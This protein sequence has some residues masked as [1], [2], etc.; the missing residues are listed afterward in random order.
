MLQQKNNPG[1]I[2][3]RLLGGLVIACWLVACAAPQQPTSSPAM[4]TAFNPDVTLLVPTIALDSAATPPPPTTAENSPT[5]EPSPAADCTI[6]ET[7]GFGDDGLGIASWTVYCDEYYGFG[8]KYP[9]GGPPTPPTESRV[10]LYLPIAPDTTLVEKY[11]LVESTEGDPDCSSTL[12]QGRLPDSPQAE[13]ISLSGLTFTRQAGGDAAAGSIYDWVTY[14]TAQAN[15][16]VSLSFVLHH[17]N[18]ANYVPPLPEFDRAAESVVF[19]TI[20][21]T[22]T[23]LR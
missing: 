13:Q 19:E 14:S 21:A 12:A 22:F 5:Q 15:N 20:A 2:C 11:I 1:A 9:P 3:I 10:I 17:A 23:W 4:P 7:L 6:L 16:C 18:A 8:F